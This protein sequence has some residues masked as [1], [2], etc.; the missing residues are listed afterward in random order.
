MG[1][2]LRKP[3]NTNVTERYKDKYLYGLVARLNNLPVQRLEKVYTISSYIRR[4]LSYFRRKK[5]QQKE[6]EICNDAV[7]WFAPVK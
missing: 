5:T 1:S 2:V 7:L 6:A 4:G 3:I